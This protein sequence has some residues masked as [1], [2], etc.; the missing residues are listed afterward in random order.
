V[1]AIRRPLF[2]D[3][4]MLVGGNSGGD[5]AGDSGGDG[6]S[7]LGDDGNGEGSSGC[8]VNGDIGVCCPGSNGDGGD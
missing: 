4:D 8:G 6:D 5:G 7:T 1:D 2:A 3:D